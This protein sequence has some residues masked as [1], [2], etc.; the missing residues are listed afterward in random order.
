MVLRLWARNVELVGID[1]IHDAP[2]KL[3]ELG[4]VHERRNLLLLLHGLAVKRELAF[5]RDAP[6]RIHE[7]VKVLQALLFKLVGGEV[8]QHDIRLHHEGVGKRCAGREHYA[9]VA[10]VQRLDVLRL[11][12]HID[13]PLA[14]ALRKTACAPLPRGDRHALE[15]VRLVHEKLVNAKFLERHYLAVVVL[16]VRELFKLRLQAFKLLRGLVHGNLLSGLAH[17]R[18]RL[19]EASALRLDKLLLVLVGHGELLGER[20]MLHHDCVPVAVRHLCEERPAVLRL[21]VG[22]GHFQDVRV[23][24]RLHKLVRELFKHVV[25]NDVHRLLEESKMPSKNTNRLHFKRLSRAYAMRKA[26]RIAAEDAARDHVGLVFAAF[27]RL[28]GIAALKELAKR[29]LTHSGSAE[30]KDVVR[31]LDF[32]HV[33]HNGVVALVHRRSPLV[34]GLD[35]LRERMV[36]LFGRE[37]V[38]LGAPLVE[39][40]LL[41]DGIGVVVVHRTVIQHAA[42]ELLRRPAR[43]TPRVL[44]HDA[45]KLHVPLPRHLV[46]AEIDAHGLRA[47]SVTQKVLHAFRVNPRRAELDLRVLQAHHRRLHLFKGLDVR[48][49]GFLAGFDRSPRRREFRADAPGEI[50][51]RR[52]KKPRLR[53]LECIAALFQLCDCLLVVNA[54]KLRDAW[55]VD[56][57]HFGIRDHERV[58][59]RVGLRR[60][61][62]ARDYAL[63]EDVGLHDL[64]LAVLVLHHSFKGEQPVSVR[65]V[66]K[67]ERR[68]PLVVKRSVF[69][70][71]RVVNLVQLREERRQVGFH[72]VVVGHLRV[73]H[74]AHG[75]A[76]VKK[77][78]HDLRGRL[79]ALCK[80]LGEGAVVRQRD[81]LQHFAALDERLA[82]LHRDVALA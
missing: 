61:L 11:H 59:R 52:F 21:Y 12:L 41:I 36:Q 30:R 7:I 64:G 8:F 79:E 43:F 29:R 37:L 71:E 72:H 5:G 35:E 51:P 10:A 28:L 68:Y 45:P 17:G 1:D 23:R 44:V 27:L 66:E 38:P 16:R 80:L 46:L 70:H 3:H 15:V 56:C 4:D 50:F 34:A 75:L 9:T 25:W 78:L 55:H 6:E 58:L 31:Q 49:V 81:W 76:Q 74:F 57:A 53:V 42:Y 77:P 39:I 67:D 2:K 65:L 54:Q 73:D 13:G 20:G 69:L 14:V 48:A 60:P 22:L 33:R 32:H 82:V 62:A 19:N 18:N 63:R 26:E 24:K 47:E 40:A